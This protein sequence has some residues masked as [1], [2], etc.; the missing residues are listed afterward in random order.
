MYQSRESR[1]GPSDN[2]IPYRV[3]FLLD[4][5]ADV[6]NWLGPVLRLQVAGV[7]IS[8]RLPVQRL[9]LLRLCS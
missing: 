4:A 3:G 5:A 1:E 8:A 9:R 7:S 2:A 6:I